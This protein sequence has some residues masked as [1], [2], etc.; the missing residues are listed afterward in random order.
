MGG[1]GRNNGGA[2][3]LPDTTWRS[4]SG[5]VCTR[6]RQPETNS[7]GSWEAA[8]LKRAAFQGRYFARGSWR[9]SGAMMKEEG[10]SFDNDMVRGREG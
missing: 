7:V 5:W 4:Y 1:W 8:I 10:T 9:R 6:N 3:T 2:M